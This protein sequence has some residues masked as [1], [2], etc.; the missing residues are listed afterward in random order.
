MTKII[1]K[2]GDLLQAPEPMIVHGCNA[3]GVMGSGVAKLIR[4]R[5]PQAYNCYRAAYE[6]NGLKVGTVITVD[7]GKKMIANAITQEFY[8]RDP[9]RVYVDY[10][11][12]SDCMA[13]INKRAPMYLGEGGH[14]AMPLIGAG[15]AGGEWGRIAEIIEQE[16]TRFQ[17][18]VYTLDGDR[19]ALT[20][21]QPTCCERPSRMLSTTKENVMQTKPLILND[22]TAQKERIDRAVVALTRV[23][24]WYYKDAP[25]WKVRMGMA[26]SDAL[27]ANVINGDYQSAEGYLADLLEGV[28]IAQER[29]ADW[30]SD[31]DV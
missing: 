29:I 14:V 31:L 21:S 27:H 8:G 25:E 26:F 13:H 7:V 12:V 9:R 4:D 10:Q 6:A 23:P 17:P 16:S 19:S 3:Q 30:G 28:E 5:W 1:Y 15:L 22:L 11:A 20:T 2:T 18:V 24:A